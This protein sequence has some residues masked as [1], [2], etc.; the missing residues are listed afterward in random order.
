MEEYLKSSRKEYKRICKWVQQ[1][2][3]E[4]DSKEVTHSQLLEEAREIGVA[5]V[6]L[7]TN[8]KKWIKLLEK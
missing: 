1:L 3:A 7:C 5:V 8:E 4:Y 6:G 2:N